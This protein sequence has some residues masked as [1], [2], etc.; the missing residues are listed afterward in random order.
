MTCKIALCMLLA[1]TLTAV[2]ADFVSHHVERSGAFTLAAPIDKAFPL[3]EPIPEKQWAEGWDPKPVYPASGD[4][5]EG[6]VFLSSHEHDNDTVWTLAHFDP[7]RHEITYVNVTPGV[8]VGRIDIH[9]SETAGSTRVDV[10]YSFTGLNDA[11]NEFVDSFSQSRFDGH[12]HSWQHAISYF[13]QT[14]KRVEHHAQP[15][16]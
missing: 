1:S 9:C 2:A 13:L 14:G 10:R 4:T 8:R 15:S 16:L 6:M 11:G 12:M 3:F 7:A 5:R